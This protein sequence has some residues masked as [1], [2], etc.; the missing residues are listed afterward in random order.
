[1]PLKY[2]IGT[3]VSLMPAECVTNFMGLNAQIWNAQRKLRNNVHVVS[4]YIYNAD[5]SLR[6]YYFESNSYY[7]NA[8]Y[9]IAV[10]EDLQQWDMEMYHGN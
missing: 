3:K 10:D 9:V 2:P 1:M 4:D 7:W 5:R 6:G 8:E